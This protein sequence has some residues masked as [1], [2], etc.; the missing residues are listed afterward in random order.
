MPPAVLAGLLDGN[1]LNLSVYSC[2]VV[3][4]SEQV[5]KDEI[6]VNRVI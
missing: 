4:Q 5:T 3:G 6:G 2:S 1:V